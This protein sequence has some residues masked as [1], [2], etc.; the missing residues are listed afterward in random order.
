MGSQLRC[1]PIEHIPLWPANI[2]LIR[3][4]YRLISAMFTT[5]LWDISCVSLCLISKVNAQWLY[6][7]WALQL[8]RCNLLTPLS[9]ACYS[10]LGFVA[11]RGNVLGRYNAFWDEWV[12]LHAL[13]TSLLQK[14]LR[15]SPPGVVCTQVWNLKELTEG[16]HKNAWSMWLNLTQRGKTYRVRTHW[17]LTGDKLC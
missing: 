9:R 2:K 10:P 6:E 3:S 5:C 12:N 14:C 16:H 13:G 15:H 17:G 4:L 1:K 7:L 11:A 8:K